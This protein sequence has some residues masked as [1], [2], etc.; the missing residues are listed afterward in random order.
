VP[1]SKDEYIF[2]KA[3]DE[4]KSPDIQHKKSSGKIKVEINHDYIFDKTALNRIYNHNKD[5]KCIVFIRN[6][7]DYIISEYNYCLATGY[8][9][10]SFEDYLNQ[11]AFIKENIKFSTHLENLYEIFKKKNIL[12]LPLEML[13]NDSKMFT[14]KLCNFMEINES[15]LD[16]YDY[17]MQVNKALSFR[18]SFI[19]SLTQYAR[20]VRDLTGMYRLYGNL[21]NSKLRKILFKPKAENDEERRQYTKLIL[22]W[23]N[24]ILDEIELVE[25][26]T[27]LDL[28]LIKNKNETIL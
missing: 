27:D 9:N 26:I 13:K 5:I 16:S 17:S 7:I 19:P 15:F 21:K 2:S 25:E 18:Y 22:Q 10:S 3:Y 20:K 8:L 28:K 11:Q 14:N 12:C 24:T 1:S 4:K 6:P 23:N